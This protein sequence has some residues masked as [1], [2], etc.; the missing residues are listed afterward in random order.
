VADAL[1]R[2]TISATGGAEWRGYVCDRD[3]LRLLLDLH[4]VPGGEATG[5]KFFPW[6][7]VEHIMIQEAHHLRPGAVLPE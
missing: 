5:Y 1:R 6:S 4:G 3:G 2:G 7:S